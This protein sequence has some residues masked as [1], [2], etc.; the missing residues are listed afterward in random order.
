MMKHRFRTSAIAL[1]ALVG[2]VVASWLGCSPAL[3]DKRVALVIG[4]SAYK[5]APKLGN[6]VNDAAL[7]GGMLKRSGFDTVDVRQDLN[8]PEMR[9]ALR[10]FGARTRDA[11]VAIV[12]Y[13]GH[14]L[15]VDG[16]NYL[17]P[18]DAALETDTD[19]Y[20]EALPIDR[21][22]VSIEPAKQLR[23]VILDACRDNPF[24]KTMK[25]TVASRAIGRGLAKVEPTSPN[26]MIAFAAKA[27]STASDG[28]S[29]NSPFA[30]ALAD[31]LPK[32]GLDLRKAFGFVR[33]DVL[34]S[35][36]NKQEPF[37]YG[38]LG[39]DDVPLVPAK[40]VATGPQPN[41]QS[42][43]RRDYELALQLGTRDGWEAFLAQYPEG[44]YANL[45][46][47]QL[48]KIGAEETRASAE[49]KAKAAEQEKTRLVAERAQKVEQDK[50][51]AAAKTAEEAR[52]AA[53][54]Q[55]QIE[56]ARTEAAEQQRKV[57][58]AAAAKAQAE[59]QAAEKAKAELAA[60]QA[61]EKASAEQTAK[62]TADRQIP[63]AGS[64]KVAALA[65]APTSNVSAADLAKSVQSEL[66]RVGCLASAADGEWSSA[67]QRSL[68][69]F[70]KYAGTQFDVKLASVDALDALKAKPGRVCPLICNFGFKADGDQCAKIACRAGYRVGDDNE[71]EKIQ[72]KKPVATRE[73]SSRRDAERKATESSPAKPEASG[74]II[75]SSTGC[76]PVQKGCRLVSGTIP[77]RVSSNVATGGN[78]EVC[79]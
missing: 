71:C 64:Q 5:S 52:I 12:Y 37:V 40:P 23:L 28:D 42:E 25:R 39:G 38:S 44:F 54:K 14:G 26:T 78:F 18:I 47:G 43:L 59:K 69:L 79:N 58:E 29:R 61:A 49:Q 77:G 17:I 72:E 16:T 62:Q 10:E 22:L 63:E 68:T 56:Q 8:A 74:Q 50:A 57:A 75:C 65:P 53:E 51:A 27:G 76:R 48:N 11:D 7:I 30:T 46:K 34:K 67:A 33:D 13:A 24:S 21:V 9:K 4:N 32:P 6:P 45:A 19:V 70:N 55:K 60:R 35:T 15:E 31:H 3:A 1:T 2:S 41:P 20:D 66:R 36:A 73:N